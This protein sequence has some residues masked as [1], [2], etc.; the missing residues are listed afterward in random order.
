[1]FNIGD[2]VRYRANWC[3]PG[4]EKYIH[5]VKEIRLNPVT[6]GNR[7]LIETINTL[8]TLRPTETVDECMIEEIA[9]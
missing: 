8:L 4:E 6:G 9:P 1:M 7:Y 5:I 2:V 3:S